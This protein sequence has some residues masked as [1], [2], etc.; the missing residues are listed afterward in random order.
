MGGND[1][2]PSHYRARQHQRW[3]RSNSSRGV[4]ESAEAW[5]SGDRKTE[6]EPSTSTNQVKVCRSRSVERDSGWERSNSAWKCPSK[7]PTPIEWTLF[8]R[9]QKNVEVS[10]RLEDLSI[11]QIWSWD[12]FIYIETQTMWKWCKKLLHFLTSTSLHCLVWLNL[13]S[14]HYWTNGWDR[15]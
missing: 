9:W 6:G 8:A 10:L 7:W 11:K 5:S 4:E 2:E 3:G 12:V 1:G 13:Q 14:Q 15:F